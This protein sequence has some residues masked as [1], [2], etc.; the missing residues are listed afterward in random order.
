LG[1]VKS[2]PSA[3][4]EPLRQFRKTDGVRN[5]GEGFNAD[6][7]KDVLLVLQMGGNGPT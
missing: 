2:L 7:A 5:P 1:V 6:G 4:Q 3:G